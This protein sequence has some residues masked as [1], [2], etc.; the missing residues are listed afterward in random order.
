MPSPTTQVELKDRGRKTEIDSEIENKRKW[1]LMG[2]I[3]FT[4][5][6]SEDTDG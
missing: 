3:H 2:G 1:L 6:G 5:K 4:H